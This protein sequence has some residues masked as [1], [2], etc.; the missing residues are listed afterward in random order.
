MTVVKG[1]VDSA[2][3]IDGHVHKFVFLGDKKYTT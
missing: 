3:D 1:I 2:A